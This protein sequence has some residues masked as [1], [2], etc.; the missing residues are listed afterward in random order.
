[1]VLD[2][3]ALPESLPFNV[4]HPQKTVRR[5]PSAAAL[6]RRKRPHGWDFTGKKKLWEFTGKF[7]IYTLVNQQFS[8]ENCPQKS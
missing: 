6:S 7:Q 8:I 5:N 3:F 2:G 1:M 4:E